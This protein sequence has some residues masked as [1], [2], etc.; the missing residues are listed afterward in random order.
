MLI[1][2]G[3]MPFMGFKTY[4]RIAGEPNPEKKPLLL[5]HG[6]PGSTHNSFELL[7]HVGLPESYINRYP[8]ELSGGQRQRVA[9]AAALIQQPELIFLD[10]PVSALDVTVQAQILRLLLNVKKLYR[11]SKLSYYPCVTL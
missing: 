8:D 7:D 3:Y 10:E 9:I 1:T 5:L 6:G 2:E 4:Y 11:I